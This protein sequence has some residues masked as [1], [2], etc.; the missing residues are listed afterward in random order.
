MRVSVAPWF[1]E[2]GLHFSTLLGVALS[3]VEGQAGQADLKVGLST[4]F[5]RRLP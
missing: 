5:R 1:V 2:A 3:E 4:I